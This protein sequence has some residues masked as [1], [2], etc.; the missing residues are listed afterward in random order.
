MMVLPPLVPALLA[1]AVSC[2]LVVALSLLPWM[3]MVPP[4]PE[5]VA[6]V[7]ADPADEAPD[8][9]VMLLAVSSE[10]KAVST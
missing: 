2:W 8:A 9:R 7:A 4:L 6:A 3:R 5:E 10:A 1:K